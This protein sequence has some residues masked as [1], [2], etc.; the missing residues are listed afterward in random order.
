M[1]RDDKSKPCE[2]CGG[3][4]TKK[5]NQPWGRWHKARFCSR[6]CWWDARPNWNRYAEGAK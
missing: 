5:D 1:N 2:F 6:R 4:F 3:I